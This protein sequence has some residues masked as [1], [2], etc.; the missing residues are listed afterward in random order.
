MC[1]L[2]LLLP[3]LALAFFWIWPMWIAAPAYAAVALASG[4][5]YLYLLR[6]M[7][8]PVQ[9]GVEGLLQ[10]TGKVVDSTDDALRVQV[11]NEIWRAVSHDAL[12]AGDRVRIVGVDGLTLRVEKLPGSD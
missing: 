6:A 11:H 7:R 10:E 12:Q 9:T 3:L 5:M 2:I 4:A 8:C 1:H